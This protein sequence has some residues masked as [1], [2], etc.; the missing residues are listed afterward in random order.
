MPGWSPGTGDQGIAAFSGGSHHP[1]Q[2]RRPGE[3]K[4]RRAQCPDAPAMGW[5]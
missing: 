2:R 4:K 3:K 1:A 5:G